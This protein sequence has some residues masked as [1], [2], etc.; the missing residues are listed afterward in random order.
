MNEVVNFLKENPVQF[1]AT[2]GLDGKP[3][4]RPFQFALEQG[5]KLWFCTNSGKNV[6]KEMQAQPY[7]EVSACSQD[8]TWIR[9]SGKAVFEN[10]MDVKKNIIDAS[11]L[12]KS[13]YKDAANPIFEVFYIKEAKAVFADFSGNPPREYTL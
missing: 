8:Y 10:D 9:L 3:K 12:V 13:I 5:G 2:T 11:P 6:Y 1:F 4:V 7:V